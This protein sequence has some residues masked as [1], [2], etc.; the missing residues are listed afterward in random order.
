M[1]PLLAYGAPEPS[2]VTFTIVTTNN[3]IFTI[4]ILIGGSFIIENHLKKGQT[5]I[6]HFVLWAV[7]LPHYLTLKNILK[8]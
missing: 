5:H 2:L 3:A 4:M 8:I 1:R 7:S 6:N